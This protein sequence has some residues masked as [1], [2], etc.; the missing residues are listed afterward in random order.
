[1][2]IMK[3]KPV[4][5]YIA[6]VLIFVLIIPVS[7]VI[8]GFCVA[9][10]F[11]ETY[12]GELGEMY[13]KL[14]TTKGKKI[15]IIGT[16]GVAFG[17]DSALIEQELRS[18]GQEYTVCNFGLYG[19]IGTKVMFD[20]SEDYIKKD[21]IVLFVPELSA[22]TL[23]L[24]YSAKEMWRAADG[25]YNILTDIAKEN[26]A[27]TV[28]SF[29]AF[30]AEKVKY[31]GSGGVKTEGVYARASFDDNCDMKNADRKTNVMQGG[32]IPDQLISLS[33]ELFSDEFLKFVNEYAAKVKKRGAKTWFSF[34]PMNRLAVVDGSAE[35]AENMFTFLCEKLD[36]KV[37]SKVDKYI[38]DAEWFYDTNFHLNSA[39]MTAHTIDLLEDI[40]NELGV[41][42]P[43]KTP[44]PEKPSI[45]VPGDDPEIEVNNGDAAYFTYEDDGNGGLIATGLTDE[46]KARTSLTVP[47]AYEGKKV[48]SLAASVFAGNENIEEVIIQDN[49]GYLR[50]GSFSGCKNLERIV[51][52]HSSP[53]FV[54]VSYGLLNETEAS[55]Y[56]LKSAYTAFV[57]DYTWGWY[58]SRLVSYE[59]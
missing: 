59:I 39:G 13:D 34:P 58:T 4:A 6:I 17:V 35:A 36:Y 49:I 18:A 14:R 37:I 20:L 28:G 12:Y 1:M 55:V 53:N 48:K 41:F 16:S 57:T 22:Q 23:S 3:K 32:Y 29:A 11:S 19:A 21:D 40:K 9:P 54:G 43:T 30:T 31:A 24:Y 46:G 42:V 15:V 50:D 26:M 44:R 8:T 47:Y 2:F 38:L 7:V 51:L 25:H 56:V 27:E 45:D 52:R 10:Q 33:G 5:L